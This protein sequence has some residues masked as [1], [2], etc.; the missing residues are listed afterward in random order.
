LLAE[1]LEKL[2]NLTNI[3]AMF[4]CLAPP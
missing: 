4:G 2:Q 1:I 3:W